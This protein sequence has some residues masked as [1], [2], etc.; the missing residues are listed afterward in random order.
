MSSVT[1]MEEAKA[2]ARALDE[3]T[4]SVRQRDEHKTGEAVHPWASWPMG[5]LDRLPVPY[6][7]VVAIVTAIAAGEQLFELVLVDPSFAHV[8]PSLVLPVLALYILTHLRILKNA[9]IEA[10]N[11]LRPSVH[12]SDEVYERYARRLV[13]A[14]PRIELGL[15]AVSLGTVLFFFIGLDADLLNDAGGLPA[16]P[17]AA[18]FVVFTYTLLGWLIFCLVYCAIRH[19]RALRGLANEPLE[20]NVF[21]QSNLLPFG[22]L[23]LLG[24]LPIVAMILIPIVL[25]G[26][27]RQ[28]GYLVI[29]LSMISI[30]SLFLPLWGVHQQID[31]AKER[32]LDSIYRRLLAIQEDLLSQE[33]LHAAALRMMADRT[34][35]LTKMRELMQQSPNW[36]FKDTLAV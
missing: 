35:I 11:D 8:G 3:A 13:T 27:P 31:G 33:E 21:D 24:S 20:V 2:L 29:L 7:L 36:P 25:L 22:R 6:W 19:A 4:T 16:S 28:A 14:S 32:V 17:M 18:A 26:P 15:L 23:A 9:S 30:F 1:G 10:L 12:V 5:L 34:A